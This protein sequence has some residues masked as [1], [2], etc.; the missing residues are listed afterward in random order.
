MTPDA[1]IFRYLQLLLAQRVEVELLCQLICA[2][3]DLLQ[4]WLKMFDLSTDETALL[5]ALQALDDEDLR[6]LANVQAWSLAPTAGSARLSLD[7]WKSVL[8]SAFLAESIYTHL[9]T[10]TSVDHV[11]VRLR[12]L[13]GLSGVQLHHDQMLM[14]LHEYRGINPGLLEDAHLELRVFA[15]VDALETGHGDQLAPQLLNLDEAEMQSLLQEADHKTEQL[16]N[17][18][19]IDEDESADWSHN[20]WLLQQTSL[21]GQAMMDCAS[22]TELQQR[23]LSVSRVLFSITPL[24]LIRDHARQG[25]QLLN[26]PD[27][28]IPVTSNTSVI[29]AVGRSGQHRTVADEASLAV[30]DRQLL[31]VLGTEEALV[32]A[33]GD[34]VM[35]VNTDEDLNFQLAAELYVDE[36]ARQVARQQASEPDSTADDAAT[37]DAPLTDPVAHFRAAEEQRL[38]EIVHEANN[39]L[40][41]VRNYLHILDLSLGHNE[42]AKEQLQL[43]ARE[44][45]RASE[46]ISQARNVPAEVESAAVDDDVEGDDLEPVELE[47][48]EWLRDLATLQS[49][50]ADRYSVFLRVVAPPEPVTVLVQESKLNQVLSNLTKNAL[51]ASDVGNRIELILLPQVYRMGRMGIELCVSDEAGGLPQTTLA[52]LGQEQQSIKGGEHQGLG[53]K[54]VVD[55]CREMGAELDVA[56]SPEG[57]TFRV[58]LP[59]SVIQQ[60]ESNPSA[61]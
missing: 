5:D 48:G 1:V 27:L 51:E 7:L 54:I 46:I 31:R 6:N 28:L 8:R 12:A 40:S 29:A 58:F 37:E 2:D 9:Q 38:R 26:K 41:I 35:V 11:D 44:L 4:R 16:I 24:L 21:A 59:A 10:E 53:L 49:G 33:R 39:P 22:L 36:V 52:N 25:Y 20:I 50:L 57:S 47:L 43:I 30:I 60:P 15:V 19:A 23:H 32:V 45:K 14:D 17:R 55:L 3:A 42:D 13:L 34:V 18:L 56:T 61:Y